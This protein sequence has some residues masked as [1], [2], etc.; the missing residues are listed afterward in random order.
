M[1]S[2]MAN[3]S[4]TQQVRPV[5]VGV[6]THKKTHHAAAVDEAGR[7]LADRKFAATTAGYAALL[8][9]ASTLGVVARVGIEGTAS[10]GAGLTRFLTSRQVE[11]VEI[12]PGDKAL[13]RLRGKS[14]A[15]D[16]EAA[17]RRALA[18]TRP[19]VPKDTTGPVESIRQLNV[20]RNL[21]VKQ[22]RETML[23]IDQFL[24][25]GPDTIRERFDRRTPIARA[26]ALASSTPENDD[27]VTATLLGVLRTLAL[28]WQDTRAHVERIARELETMIAA[29]RP[30]LLAVNGIGPITAATL[31]TAVGGNGSR[32]R[33]EAALA[34][35]FGAAPIPASS[36]QTHRYRLSRGG[37]RKA[38][39]A[40]YRIAIVRL[41]HDPAARD[42]RDIR[43]AKG[44]TRRDVI[45]L[46]K[47]AICRE[48]YPI[49]CR[50]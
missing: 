46:L 25:T 37:D 34:R 27:P 43:L 42:Y 1:Q 32:I 47:R 48:I 35:L 15:S 30:E 31:L 8:A 40:L 26:K 12:S 22:Q 21:L 2:S 7:L 45:R 28:R 14:D 36:G 4:A 49:L 41:S 18:E 33:S 19:R 16:A 39:S 24:I 13:R 17:A 3:I 44:K 29:H 11:A 23:Q 9:W 6:D 5:V 10:Y 38:N 50:P 20:A